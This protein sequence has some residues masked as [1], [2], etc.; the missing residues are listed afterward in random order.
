MTAPYLVYSLAIV[1]VAVVV[2]SKGG[3]ASSFSEREFLSVITDA[4]A[5]LG[6]FF[7]KSVIPTG[8]TYHYARPDAIWLL[9]GIGG[10]VFLLAGLTFWRLLPLAKVGAAMAIFTVLLLP[11]L[12]FVYVSD[13][14]IATRYLGLAVVPVISLVVVPLSRV[15]IGPVMLIGLLVVYGVWGSA[16]VSYWR[17]DAA[18]F[19]KAVEREPGSSHVQMNYAN[20]LVVEG[21]L[22][23]ARAH[24]PLA[25][26]I[27]PNDPEILY[28]LALL[29]YQ[30]E[31][32]DRARELLE[33]C[34]HS[35]QANPNILFYLAKVRLRLNE[36]PSEIL[37]LAEKYRR[38]EPESFRSMLLL[39]DL[40]R[41]TG[42]REKF[43][44]LLKSVT[45]SETLSEKEKAI[46]QRMA[47]GGNPS[48]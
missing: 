6:M 46:F 8:L 30:T 17:N 27:S 9:G 19:S 3:H 48:P 12:G 5:K 25:R 29:E 42:D 15:R 13:S 22:Q 39:G 38:L 34:R 14:F 35:S 41:R 24:Y 18:L 4:L 43:L 7:W 2:Q 10:L 1:I 31:N 40:Y 32:D 23:Q 47:V 33:L 11:S 16:E 20:H 26:E 37:P 28:N 44:A 36:P 21:R 45:A